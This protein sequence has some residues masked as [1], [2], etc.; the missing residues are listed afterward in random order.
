LNDPLDIDENRSVWAADKP[1]YAPSPAL[2]GDIDADVAIVGGGFTGVSTA[3]HLAR[4]FP[5]RRIVLLE[6]RQLAN[7][8][9][10]RNGGQVLN[11]VNGVEHADPEHARRIYDVTRSGIDLIE[12]TISRY[13]LDT[14]W[15]RDG[16]LEVFTSP[17]RADAA[18]KRAEWL[19]AAGVPVRFVPK[20]ELR[21]TLALEGAEG[22][23]LDPHAGQLD[24]VGYLRGLKP[25]LL[26]LGVHVHEDTPVRKIVEGA[27]CAL[28][29]DGGVVRAK[30]IVL[31]TN[32]YTP[33]LGYFRDGLLPL[34]SHVVATEPLSDAEWA[35]RG[36]AGAAGFS[37]DLDRIA[38]AAHTRE[39]R[40]VFG[41][42]SNASYGYRY[43]GRTTWEGAADTGFA[44]VEDRLRRYLPRAANVRVTHRW[45]GTLAV[46]LSRVCTMGVRGEHQN[47]YFALGYS[48]HGVTLANLAGRVL[49]DLYAGEH[50]P[51]KGLPFY[52]QR[53]LWIPP[54]PFRWMGYHAF[55]AVT[56]KS[57]RRSL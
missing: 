20:A 22:A 56:G 14:R 43:G 10:G 13:R 5:E 37:D 3:L 27:T 2:A 47:V 4:R 24:G 49:C 9:S 32:A 46:T 44:A 26:D 50:A 18:A 6:A 1:P 16:C 34:H 15:R 52:Q 30:A 36:W 29:T 53:L 57:P 8:A 28:T 19:Q 42:G 54:D 45:T 31:A 39:G 35:E 23:L 12:D 55:T 41:G 25:V 7:G 38:Y 48:G 21:G 33:R 40:V 51:W 17:A 11:W